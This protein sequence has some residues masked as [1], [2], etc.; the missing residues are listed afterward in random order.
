MRIR[1]EKY[2]YVPCAHVSL[3]R[4]PAVFLLNFLFF[5]VF[6]N[7]KFLMMNSILQVSAWFAK[8][9]IR[10][11]HSNLYINGKSNYTLKIDIIENGKR[12]NWEENSRFSLQ[13]YMSAWN[14]FILFSTNSHSL[15]LTLS[16]YILLNLKCI[17]SMNIRSNNNGVM[18]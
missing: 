14:I 6:N 8:E 4:K 2:K 17:C 1:G 7:V 18:K 10:K 3:E 5:S 11:A 16:V 13:W 9:C 12:E 15:R